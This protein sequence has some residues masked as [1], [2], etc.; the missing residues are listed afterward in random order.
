MPNI[1]WGVNLFW[2]GGNLCVWTWKGNL[3][4]ILPWILFLL[5]RIRKGLESVTFSLGYHTFIFIQFHLHDKMTQLAKV[6]E[7]RFYCYNLLVTI[8][9]NKVLVIG[10]SV[11]REAGNFV[12]EVSHCNCCGHLR[13]VSICIG[14]DVTRW[15][16]ET[17]R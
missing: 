1:W 9:E 5:F 16:S 12:T 10:W 2:M 14:I 6:I 3:D 11:F 7:N 4:N 8:V 15:R 13:T 17:E